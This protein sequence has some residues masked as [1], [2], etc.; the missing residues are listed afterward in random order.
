MGRELFTLVMI[1]NVYKV[2]HD[3]FMSTLSHL[4]LVANPIANSK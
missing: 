2:S 1:G 4:I 3:L